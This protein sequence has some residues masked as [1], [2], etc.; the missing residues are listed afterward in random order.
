MIIRQHR[1]SSIQ[2][3]T[4]QWAVVLS[5]FLATGGVG[6]CQV[7]TRTPLPD[8]GPRLPN[9]VKLTFDP[10]LTS[11][12]MQYQNGCASLRDLN[13]GEEIEAVLIDAA[14]K[15][16]QAV[17][18]TGGTAA[19]IPPDTEILVTLQRSG[20]KLW[21]DNLYDRVPADMTLE[22]LLTFK[23][24]AG[25]ELGQQTISI[26]HNE[27]LILEPTQKPM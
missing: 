7:F 24:A 6:G 22:T 11:L 4:I 26:V 1:P 17:T 23:D 16:F 2:R 12:K 8:M 5:L 10:S 19:P 9:S 3:L 20:L 25:K 14:A 21:D 13:V 15:N 18:V 27:R